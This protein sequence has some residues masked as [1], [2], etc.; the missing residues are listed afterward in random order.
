LKKLLWIGGIIAGLIIV[1]IIVLTFVVKSYLK[2]E[3]LKALIIPRAEEATGRNVEIKSIDVSIFKGIVV[4]DIVVKDAQNKGDFLRVD[5]FIL[6]YSLIPLLKKQL[7]IKEIRFDSPHI[8]I[9]RDKKGRFSFQDIMERQKKKPVRKEK[10]QKTDAQLK[11]LPVSIITDKVLVSDAQINFIDEMKTLPDVKG[12]SDM[13]F[14]VRIDKE[15]KEPE[16]EGTIDLKG[17]TLIMNGREIKTRGKISIDREKILFNLNALIEGDRVEVKGKVQDYLTKPDIEKNI[18][19]KSL[20]LDKILALIPTGE[21]ETTKSAERVRTA[22]SSTIKRARPLNLTAHGQMK[23]D[24]AKFKGYEIK[25]FLLKFSYKDEILLLKPLRCDITGGDVIDAEGTAEGEFRLRYSTVV[26]DPMRVAKK[27]LKGKLLARLAKGEIKES[28]I[29]EALSA[30]TGLTDLRR[31]TFREAVFNL[32]FA[33]EKI[34]VDGFINSDHIRLKPKGIVDFDQNMNLKAEMKVSPVLASKLSEGLN[35]ISFMKDKEGWVIIPL[36]IRGTVTRPSVGIDTSRIGRAV[37][38]KIKKEIEQRIME[39][40][41][42]RTDK[43]K[44]SSEKKTEDLI[45]G[46]FGK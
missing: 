39:K 46:L 5:R 8:F 1:I 40:M 32:N 41:V 29:T 16:I 28:R 17:L 13:Q 6:D 19:S 4:N 35:K 25:D 36:T 11:A 27:S 23:V 10:T 26:S 43:K 33:N 31:L 12:T 14:T 44:G 34:D 38:R 20:D 21:K 30:F 42:P 22:K 3:S 45:R 18:Y 9:K 2:S 24:R 15:M 7:V 37:E